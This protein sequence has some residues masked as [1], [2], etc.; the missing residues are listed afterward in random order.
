M[1]DKEKE[2]TD[3]KKQSESKDGKQFVGNTDKAKN[4]RKKAEEDQ[5]SKESTSKKS[6]GKHSKDKTNKDEQADQESESEDEESENQGKASAGQKRKKSGASDTPS[7]KQKDNSKS[8]TNNKQSNG[9]VGSKHDP[10]DPPAP[11]GSNTRL[12]KVGQSVSWKALPGWVHGKVIEIVREEKDIE[13]KHM[14]GSKD[15]PRIALKTD[16]GK[17]AVHKPEACHFED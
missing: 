9:T 17:I 1:S 14:K 15:Q 4:A 7:K 8:K 16:S 2:E 12:P 13:G 10:A 5:N 11:A 3:A 6:R